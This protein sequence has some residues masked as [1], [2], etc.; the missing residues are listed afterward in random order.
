MKETIISL[1]KIVCRIAF[2]YGVIL[3]FETIANP[4]DWSLTGKIWFLIIAVILLA[5]D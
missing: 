4:L 3:L 1:L 5:Q 2:S